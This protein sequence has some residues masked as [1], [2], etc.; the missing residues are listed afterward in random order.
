MWAK[1]QDGV[2]VAYPYGLKELR[3]DRPSISFPDEMPVERLAEFGIV[4]VVSFDPPW[5]DPLTQ[6]C[7]RGWPTKSGDVWV[8][9]WNVT[10]ASPEDAAERTKSKAAEVRYLR[11]RKLAESDWTQLADTPVN[12]E[13]WATYRQSLRDIT[14]APGFPGNINWPSAP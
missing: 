5:H 14:S 1:V 7:T 13:A 9:T 6:N 10:T 2:I 4:R 8:E 3:Q 12:Q 11:D